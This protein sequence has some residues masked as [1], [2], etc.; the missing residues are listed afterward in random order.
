MLVLRNINECSIGEKEMSFFSIKRF[1]KRMFIIFLGVVMLSGYAF[2]S[3]ECDQ[4]VVEGNACTLNSQ[5]I[6]GNA[7]SCLSNVIEE[8]EGRCEQD[9]D[10]VHR[11]NSIRQAVSAKVQELYSESASDIE[12]KEGLIEKRINYGDLSDL[13]DDVESNIQVN[14]SAALQDV[15]SLYYQN[16]YEDGRYERCLDSL[17]LEI[18]LHNSAEKIKSAMDKVN[19]VKSKR[20]QSYASQTASIKNVQNSLNSAV[21]EYYKGMAVHVDFIE[22]EGLDVKLDQLSQASTLQTY[23]MYIRNR[24]LRADRELSHLYDTA[25][26]KYHA[27]LN[28]DFGVDVSADVQGNIYDD[29]ISNFSQKVNVLTSGEGDCVS[30]GCQSGQKVIVSVFSEYE[31]LLP[32]YEKAQNVLSMAKFCEGVS[33]THWHSDACSSIALEKNAAINIIDIE[34]PTSIREAMADTE[35]NQYLS[36]GIEDYLLSLISSDSIDVAAATFD[37]VLAKARGN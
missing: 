6:V 22:Q 5:T 20:K 4:L 27:Y 19:L 29:Q 30:E 18:R 25:R 13:I 7:I 10:L 1:R 3:A 12:E 34:I 11:Y 21:D 8:M 2:S 36:E 35:F 33:F 24:H 14:T 17:A 15:R 28:R 16:R 37:S 23:E 9:M 26:A 32:K 31:F